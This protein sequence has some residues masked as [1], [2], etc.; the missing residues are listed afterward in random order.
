[1]KLTVYG[2]GSWGT[3][4]AQVLADGGH[5]V[6]VYGVDASEIAD[7]REHRN[8]RYFGELPIHPG[9]VATTDVAAA[10]RGAEGIVFAVPSRFLRDALET[11]KPYISPAALLVN[12]GK[13]FDWE[14]NC[15]LSETI[16]E[17]LGERS[18]VSLIG[19]SHAEEVIERMVTSVCA[20]CADAEAAKKAQTLFSRDYFRVYV[21]DDE[22]GAE[23][24]A[25]MKNVIAI[26][27]GV[28]VGQGY[29]DN[30]KAALVTR[31]LLE[32]IRYGT[33]KGGRPETY[34]GLTGLGD[35]VVTCFSVHS[36][37]YRAGLE[38]GRRGEAESFLRENKTTVEGVNACRVIREDLRTLPFEMPIVEALYG[39]L[40][41]GK[42]PDEAIRGLMC[43]P[44]KSEDGKAT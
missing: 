24:G 10:T 26:A 35:L 44:L 41:E 40:F 37:N 39:I 43:R 9:I 2:S 38:I 29:G 32:M 12:A 16:R 36:R 25:A 4:L 5:E 31:G 13:G 15:R 42:S 6:T 28:L 18:V 21:N 27:S 11:G 23:Y 19:P 1:M 7:L 8:R 20:V 34:A 22:V 14:R 33:A 30:A 3:A 17:V